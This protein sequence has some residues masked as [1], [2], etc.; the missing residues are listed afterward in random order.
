MP[1]I[2]FTYMSK[3]EPIVT[4]QLNQ[5]ISKNSPILELNKLKGSNPKDKQ[6]DDPY[7]FKN[8]DIAVTKPII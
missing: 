1:K 6:R 3:E 2:T 7:L 4:P 8:I 5:N